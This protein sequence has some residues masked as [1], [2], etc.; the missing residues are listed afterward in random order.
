MSRLRFVLPFFALGLFSTGYL[1]GE[2]KKTEK[3]PVIVKAQLPR[4]FKQLGLSDKQK[5]DI[6][7]IQAKYAVEI[8]K[9]NDQIAALKDQSKVDVENVLTAGQKTRL[10]E[11]RS[12]TDKDKEIKK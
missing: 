10:R 4:Y 5:K 3:E 8:K 1:T 11:I 6:Y 12:G 7:L 9:L 2:D